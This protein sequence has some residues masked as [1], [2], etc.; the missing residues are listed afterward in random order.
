M[1]TKIDYYIGGLVGFLSGI[2]AIPTAFN[3]GMRSHGALLV[4]PWAA[5]ILFAALMRLAGWLARRRAVL[6]QFSK[7]IAV[8]FLNTAIDFGMLNLLSRVSGI[9]A[10]FILG[11]VNIPGFVVAVSNSYL[12]NKLWVFK[13][14]N[15]AGIFRDFPKFLAVT[16]VG[17]VINSA[18]VILLTTYVPPVLGMNKALWLNASK[19]GATVLTLVWNFTGYKLFVFRPEKS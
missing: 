10:G 2:A 15:E 4:L 6:A 8:G 13:N 17:L 11:G 7:F 18:I 1:I 16:V 19:A 5:A 12:W 3:L 9:S 14:G